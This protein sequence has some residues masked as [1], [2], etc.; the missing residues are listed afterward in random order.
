MVDL[1][2][3][4]NNLILRVSAVYQSL[5]HLIPP[6]SLRL[7]QAPGTA[8]SHL[9]GVVVLGA[10]PSDLCPP[11]LTDTD[12]EDERLPERPRD[13]SEVLDSGAGDLRVEEERRALDLLPDEEAD[14]GE[15]GDTAVGE[16]GLTV[17]LAL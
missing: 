12:E 16:L 14:K 4:T 5:E 1:L 15:H 8:R 6:D 9:F 3:H 7:L 2:C 17:P 10:N 11:H 13:L